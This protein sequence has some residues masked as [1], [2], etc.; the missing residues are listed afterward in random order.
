MEIKEVFDKEEKQRIARTVLE[1]LKDWFEV[2]ETREGYI[3]DSA[4]KPFFAAFEN[5]RAAGFICLDETGKDTAEIYVMGVLKEHHRK[6]VGR[7][8]F[9]KAKDAAKGLGYTFLQVKTVK[10]GMYDDYDDTNRF[11]LAL[12]FKEFEVIPEFWDKDNPCQVYV[13]Y[14]G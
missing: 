5:G 11:Y 4:D 9:E 8:L 14:L 12:G 1:G 3:R 6:G 13:M 2:A 10:M 7:L